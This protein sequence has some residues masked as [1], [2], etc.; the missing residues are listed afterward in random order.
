MDK[1]W[2]SLKQTKLKPVSLHIDTSYF[3]KDIDKLNPDV[4]TNIALLILIA[5]SIMPSTGSAEI[6]SDVLKQVASKELSIKLESEEPWYVQRE[7]VYFKIILESKASRPLLLP[8][9]LELHKGDIA[10]LFFVKY[11]D[12]PQGVWMDAVSRL[13]KPMGWQPCEQTAIPRV[14]LPGDKH[15]VHL[16]RHEILQ[17]GSVGQ[18][19]SFWAPDSTGDFRLRYTLEKFDLVTTVSVKPVESYEVRWLSY[20][21]T[22]GKSTRLREVILAKAQ[23]QTIVLISN[24]LGW[25]LPIGEISNYLV[26]HDFKQARSPTS[27]PSG[28]RLF[29]L[30]GDVTFRDRSTRIFSADRE[31]EFLSNGRVVRSVNPRLYPPANIKQLLP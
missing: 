3:F 5:L 20:P 23:E 29:T 12:I 6:C 14:L 26:N 22:D 16:R 10:R 28:V 1:V 31:I 17:D 27:P 9:D 15:E 25:D 7:A 24:G 21:S 8:Q 18:G 30:D 2:S 19:Q 4:M 13:P 11:P